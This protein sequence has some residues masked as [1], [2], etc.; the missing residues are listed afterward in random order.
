ML[1]GSLD[2][3]AA[4]IHDAGGICL[5]GTIIGSPP[6]DG[7]GC[8]L[9]F[10][11]PG[12]QVLAALAARALERSLRRGDVL[13]HEGEPGDRMYI[14]GEGKVKLGQTSADGREHRARHHRPAPDE[15]PP[16]RDRAQRPLHPRR[17]HL[18]YIPA[19]NEVRHRIQ[20]RLNGTRR[21]LAI[22]HLHL[23]GVQPIDPDVQHRPPATAPDPQVHE[24]VAQRVKF[25]LHNIL[26]CAMHF[27]SGYL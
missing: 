12:S 27:V 23:L 4:A 9:Y 25:L 18:Q 26:Q 19:I 24:I 17:R 20:P 5:D 14:I 2:S 13:F 15:A 6:R 21:P 16:V 7:A 11:G 22:P 1:P 8:N 10:S 3:T